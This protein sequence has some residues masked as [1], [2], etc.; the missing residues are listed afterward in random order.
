LYFYKDQNPVCHK[1]DAV[2]RMV[3]PLPQLDIIEI[4]LY[5][6]YLG[7]VNTQNL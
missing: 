1:Q 7:V 3:T 5:K 6:L 4:I 2:S